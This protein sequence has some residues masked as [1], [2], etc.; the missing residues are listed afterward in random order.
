VIYAEPSVNDQ[1]TELRGLM[2]TLYSPGRG[3][4]G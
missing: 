3:A 4:T 1:I 2:G